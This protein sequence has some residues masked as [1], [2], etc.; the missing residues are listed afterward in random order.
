MRPKIPEHLLKIQSC[1]GGQERQMAAPVSLPTLFSWYSKLSLLPLL[2][3]TSVITPQAFSPLPPGLSL[4]PS[5]RSQ[6]C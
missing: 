2:S 1:L 6:L 5:E 4:T 3:L